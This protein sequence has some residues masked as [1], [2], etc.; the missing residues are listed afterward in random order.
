MT[1]LTPVTPNDSRF[2]IDPIKY[3]EGLT[4]MNMYESYGHAM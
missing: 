1:F 4:L 2:T 3:V